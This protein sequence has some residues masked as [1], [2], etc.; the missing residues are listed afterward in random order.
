MIKKLML[1]ML[2]LIAVAP[3]A[4]AAEEPSKVAVFPFDVFSREP[5]DYLKTDLQAMLGQRLSKEGVSVLPR[6]EVNRALKE[7]GKPLDLSLAR[8]LAGSLGADFAVYGSLTKIGNRVSLDV[9]ILDTLGMVRPQSV[10]MEGAGLESLSGLS[11][12]LAAEVAVK[13]SGR[14]RVAQVIIKGNK[15]IENDAVL[16]VI[17]TKPGGV[18][19]PV[20]LDKDL[21]DV[22]KMGYFDDVRLE[23][24]DSPKGKVVTFL[25]KEKPT[26]REVQITGN[27]AIDTKDIRDAIDLK[28]FGVFKPGAIK[29]AEAKI[30]KMYHDKGFYDV[31]VQGKV[32][33]LPSKD[34]GIRI[35]VEEGK[36]VF[37][38][39]ILF[40]GNKAYKDSVL[41]DQ[42]ST[43]QE[44]WLSWIMDDNLLDS[45][46][47]EQDREK[48]ADFY[49]N[50]GYLNAR[51]GEPKIERKK[52]GLYI[53]FPVVEGPRFKVSS[54]SLSGEMLMP[55]AELMKQL[56]SKP[57]DWFNRAQ[58]RNDLTYLHDLY[59]DRGYAYVS[60]RPRIRQ[61]REK[62]TVAISYHLKKGRKVWFERII[63]TGNTRT[64][65]NVIRRE[66]GVVEGA[67]FSSKAL[68]QSNMRLRRLNFFEDVH[69]TTAKGASP[70]RMDVKINVKEKRTGNF[71]VG[72]GY[73]TIDNL[74]LMGQVAESNLFGRGQRLEFRAAVGGSSNRYTISFTEPWLFDRPVSFG[75][76]VFNWQR[77]YTNYD[78]DSVGGRIRFG[79]PTR[80]AYTRFY[81]YYKYEVA[82][83]TDVSDYAATIIKDQRGSHTTSSIKGILRRDSRNHPWNPN[84]GSDNSIS[85]EYAGGPIG[86]TN[87]FVK[88]IADS[89]WYIPVWFK[90][91][92]VLHGRAGWLTDH[93]GGDL[94][95]YEKFFLGG[96]NTLRGFDFYSVGPKDPATGDVIGGELMALFNFE[97]RFPLLAKAGL[98]GV[99]FYDTGNAWTE[100]QGWDIGSLRKSVGGGI[101]WYSPMGPLRLEYGWVLDP[102]PGEA[103]SQWEFTIGG[104]F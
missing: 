37:I 62:R 14:A 79:F 39:K 82:D 97:Y 38:K 48:L 44:G 21:R 7:S 100:D 2:V 26:L 91:V 42:M 68:R 32:V 65:D 72:A 80:F 99:A 74:M 92:V 67:L 23:T 64:R 89:G 28:P 88:A 40:S 33:D 90:H 35:K 63:I 54:V 85:L 70:D 75:V 36:K 19:S 24:K 4:N 87:A 15:R 55:Q 96:I 84:H 45:A 103:T 29:E 52:E 18:Y 20:R 77:E 25:V 51:I 3:L 71:S 66:L 61:N 10:F 30:I 59:A 58:V 93:S 9:K 34:K 60:V 41:R 76:D 69:I 5:L 81:A 56:K 6:A 13:V 11:Q 8:R 17:K 46:K 104:M 73:S 102:Q 101:R 57:G 98:I 49:F 86:G 83:V 22:W 16:A 47:L 12:K 31:K 94:P 1:M 53:T 27:K 43:Q 78:K 95:I 50:N